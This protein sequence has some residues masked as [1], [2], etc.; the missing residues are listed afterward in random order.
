M[1][2]DLAPE[3]PVRGRVLLFTSR[4]ENTEP[5]MSM[6]QQLSTC[7][8]PVLNGLSGRYSLIRS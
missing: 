4:E 8:R 2:V 1:D 6:T 5:T 7:V 3:G